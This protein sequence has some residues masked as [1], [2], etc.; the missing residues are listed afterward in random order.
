MTMR[1]NIPSIPDASET[2]EILNGSS[3]V[4][5]AKAEKASRIAE[6]RKLAAQMC[7]RTDD[8]RLKHSRAKDKR[9]AEAMAA[10]E[11]AQKAL[12]D[13]RIAYGKTL[14]A[15]S[16]LAHQLDARFDE[17]TRVL[18]E[19]SDPS[20]AL[21]ISEMMDAW[22]DT[23]KMTRIGP[24]IRSRNVITGKVNVSIESNSVSVKDRLKAIRNAIQQAEEMK[25]DV[26][27]SSVPER[28][29]KLRNELPVVS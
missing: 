13:A 11:A 28:L 3:F 8:E 19:T 20:I 1:E 18:L 2:L 4:Q 29:Q 25:L 14:A 23:R 17:A 15:D 27:Q 26:D 9:H 22:A 5:Q 24:E 16:N 21:F 10:I 7:A 6:Q 12:D